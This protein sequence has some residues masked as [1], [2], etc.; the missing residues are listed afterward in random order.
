[1]KK[2]SPR[3]RRQAGRH[4][5]AGAEGGNELE[6]LIRLDIESVCVTQ[7]RPKGRSMKGKSLSSFTNIMGPHG[8]R[9]GVDFFFFF[10]LFLCVCI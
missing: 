7:A 8:T 4:R 9:Q 3:H 1:M 6:S 2:K 10:S 5:E